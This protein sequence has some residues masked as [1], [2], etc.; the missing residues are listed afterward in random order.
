MSRETGL[1]RLSIHE[2]PVSPVSSVSTHF[3]RLSR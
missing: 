1:A 2:A 3:H